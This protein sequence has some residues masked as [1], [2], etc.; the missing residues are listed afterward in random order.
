MP[1]PLSSADSVPWTRTSGLVRLFGRR[2]PPCGIRTSSHL[3][4]RGCAELELPKPNYQLL[5]TSWARTSLR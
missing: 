1:T 4:L 3:V 5:G 2:P